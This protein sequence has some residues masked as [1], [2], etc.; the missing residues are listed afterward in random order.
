MAKKL[1]QKVFWKYFQMPFAGY[2]HG[3]N[4][5]FDVW[6]SS[7][8]HYITVTAQDLNFPHIEIFLGFG[9]I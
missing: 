1:R 3:E 8:L 4:S 5:E 9:A 2:S 7:N 6:T